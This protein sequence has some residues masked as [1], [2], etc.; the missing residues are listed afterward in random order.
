MVTLWK[1][2]ATITAWFLLAGISITALIVSG[3]ARF[4]GDVTAIILVPLVIG[5]FVT[6]A[7]WLAGESDKH[8]AAAVTDY[9]KAKRQPGDANTKLRLLLELMDDDEREAFKETLKRRVLDDMTSGDGELL[10]DAA[11]LESLL[12]DQPAHLYRK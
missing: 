3:D 5:L 6:M 12:S 4:S 10:A 9:E 2:V 7:I 8:E 1:V 11:T